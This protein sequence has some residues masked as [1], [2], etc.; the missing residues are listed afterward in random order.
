VCTLDKIQVYDL[1]F[2]KLGNRAETKPTKQAKLTNL[3]FS[4]KDPVI[5]VGDDHGG[6]TVLKLSPNLTPHMVKTGN[7]EVVP[8]GKTVQQY[9]E[10]KMENMLNLVGKFEKDD[11]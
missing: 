11:M 4:S 9:E 2:D 10:E 7:T 3:V 8:E 6:V 5:L 1:I